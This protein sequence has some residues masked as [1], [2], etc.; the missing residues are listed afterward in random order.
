MLLR[1]LAHGRRVGAW[2]TIPMSRRGSLISVPSIAICPEDTRMR[3]AIRRSK[4]DFPHPEGPTME[5]NSLR[6]MLRLTF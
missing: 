3:P 2:N 6:L 4:V 1:M 5:T